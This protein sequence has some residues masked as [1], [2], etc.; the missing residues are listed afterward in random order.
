MRVAARNRCI[1]PDAYGSR[2]NSVSLSRH[3]GAGM[4]KA[5]STRPRGRARKARRSAPARTGRT[6]SAR[7]IDAALAALA[8]EVRT[9]LTGILALSELIAASDLPPRE[10]GWAAAVKGAA[11]HLAQL[12]TLVV[13]GA[14]S[15]TRTL[16]LKRE[17][18][19]PRAVA[20]AVAVA[21][22]AR[23]EAKGLAS[24]IDIGDE[25]PDLAVGDAVRL[26]AAL[27]NLIDN[28]VKFTERGRI[29]FRATAAPAARGRVRLT[30]VVEDS[31][32]GLT[33]AEIGRLFRPF[34]QASKQIARRFGGAGL[35]LAFVRR[36]AKAMGGDAT[37][38]SAPGR[39]STFRLAVVVGRAA[40]ADSKPA[41][42]PAAP[43]ARAKALRILCAEDNP[44]GRVVLNT[45]LTELGHR[46]DFAAGG[47]AAV[48]AAAAGGYDMVLM[49]V[50]LPGISGIEAARRIRAL[51]GPSARVPIIGVSGRASPGDETAARAAGMDG[52]L[53]KPLSP[54][55]LAET[56][57][58]CTR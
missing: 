45:I 31:G 50:T 10:R 17:T 27:E 42:G 38:E 41:R 2:E 24:E 54:S 6:S 58:A 13:D 20:Q 7:A 30:F 29:G 26:R 44:Y 28:A 55:L 53:M 34:A 47:E 39:G 18:F 51:A 32:L 19:R 15:S 33:R 52:Y 40:D 3:L 14:K 12:T 36:V 37:V 16:A 9:P 4:G 11:E 43:G 5:R 48:E 21:L 25:L 1:S 57:A 35:G 8:H 46:V 56:I 23:A 22:A 49:D